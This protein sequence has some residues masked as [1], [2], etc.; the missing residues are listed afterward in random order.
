MRQLKANPIQA[1]I[2]KYTDDAFEKLNRDMIEYNKCAAKILVEAP[3]VGALLAS[4]L[5][6]K[7]SNLIVLARDAGVFRLVDKIMRGKVFLEVRQ[8]PRWRLF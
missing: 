6:Y 4:N 1:Y 5:D 3:E 2:Q 7:V 8:R